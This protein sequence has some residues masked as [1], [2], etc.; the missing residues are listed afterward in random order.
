VKKHTHAALFAPL[1]A[2]TL[3]L[4]TP[5]THAQVTSAD[6]VISADQHFQ[7]ALE[8]QA[9]RDYR[10]M[11][12]QLKTAARLGHVEAQETLG[13]VLLAGPAVYGKAIRADR[14]EALRWFLAAAR[15]GSDLGR[16][17]VDFLNRARSAPRGRP[18]CEE[19]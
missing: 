16:A 7:L 13:T 5:A 2:L 11:L 1:F 14:C 18:A 4:G 10:T 17:Q 9:E 15:S 6:I 12:A 3:A 8:S 19:P